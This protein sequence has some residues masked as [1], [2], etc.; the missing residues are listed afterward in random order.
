LKTGFLVEP[1]SVQSVADAFA[2]YVSHPQEAQSI[3]RAAIQAANDG[4]TWKRNAARIV[5]IYQSVAEGITTAQKIP[6]N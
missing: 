5:E 4:F 6:A 1:R 3:A 2:W